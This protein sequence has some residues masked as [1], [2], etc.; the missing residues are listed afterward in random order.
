MSGCPVS[1]SGR[2]NRPLGAMA[3]HTHRLYDYAASGNC[4]KVRLLIAQ[5][6]LEVERVPVD[7]FAGE[8]LTPEF[9]A[10]NP[11]R[12][13]PVLELPDGRHLPESGAILAYLARGTELLPDDP[14]AQAQ[15]LRWLLFEQTALTPA[16]AGLRFRLLTGRLAPGDARAKARHAAGVVMLRLLDDHLRAQPFLVGDAYT[17]ADI[18]LYGYTHVAHEAGLPTDRFAAV[19]AWL[20]RVAAQPG[21]IND[22]APYP[23]NARAGAG[24]SIYG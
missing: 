23:A 7:I 9:A 1:Q 17:I 10:I 2:V 11:A 5:V 3:N 19:Q 12:T 18:A 22:V 8:T 20:D 15:V 16:I 13:V 21:H 14:F 4:Y 6:G 24:T